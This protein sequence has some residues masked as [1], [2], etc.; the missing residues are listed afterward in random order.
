MSFGQF[1]QDFPNQLAKTFL[2][3]IGATNRR[4]GPIR[5]TTLHTNK[6]KEST[7]GT[8]RLGLSGEQLL[9]YCIAIV[10]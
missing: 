7:M 4:Q 8:V 5:L 1:P 10:G 6:E 3:S 2:P 9:A